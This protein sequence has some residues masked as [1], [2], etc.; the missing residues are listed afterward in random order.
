MILK[1]ET[2][3]NNVKVYIDKKEK[4]FIIFDIN[5]E[6]LK[7]S[8]DDVAKFLIDISEYID[9]DNLT[10]EPLN[11]NVNIKDNLKSLYFF[12]H[13]MFNKFFETYNKTKIEENKKIE[14]E[15]NRLKDKIN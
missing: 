12:I 8:T 7:I 1:F 11:K 13:E 15:L 4:I 6:D 3:N 10:I 5:N 9:S 2:K 14:K